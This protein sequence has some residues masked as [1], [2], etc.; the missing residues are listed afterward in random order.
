MYMQPADKPCISSITTEKMQVRCLK[1]TYI[2]EIKAVLQ[3]IYI[4]YGCEGYSPSLAISAKIEITSN[5]NIDSRLRF[6]ISFNAEFQE[7]ELIGIWA[8]IPIEYKTKEEVEEV[9][10][11]LPE[12]EPINFDDIHST[13]LDLKDYPYEIKQWMI[14]V[15]LGIM[16]ITVIATLIVIIWKIYHMR[17]TLGELGKVFSVMKDKPNLTG[18]LEAGK[19][20]QERLNPTTPSGSSGKRTIQEL[21]IKPE[22]AIPLYKAIGEF[23]SE[24]LMKKYL[25]KVKKVNETRKTPEKSEEVTTDNT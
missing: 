4:G 16:T 9:V 12:R 14:L 13:I 25:S 6:F 23:S 10:E 21:T 7:S 24:K 2:V 8:G 22:V 5:F 19:A 1:E 17:G 11:Q 3:I 18:L 15:I 20:V